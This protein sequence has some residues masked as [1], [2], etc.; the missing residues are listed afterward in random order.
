[1]KIQ[2]DGI[3][4]RASDLGILMDQFFLK[5]MRQAHICNAVVLIWLHGHA[6]TRYRQGD[7]LF[8]IGDLMYN[9]KIYVVLDRNELN[10]VGTVEYFKIY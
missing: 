4:T 2:H 8:G 1:M 10:K 3:T 9:R 6:K 5:F 7:G